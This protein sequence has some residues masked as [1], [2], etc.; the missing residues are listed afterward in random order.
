MTRPRGGRISIAAIHCKSLSGFC[1]WLVGMARRWAV[2]GRLGEASPSSHWM[3]LPW[4][5][6]LDPLT[7]RAANASFF[8]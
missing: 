2:R 1:N 7:L 3:R 4:G 8:R 6:A 5:L